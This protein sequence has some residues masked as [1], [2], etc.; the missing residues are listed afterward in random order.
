MLALP[1]TPITVSLPRNAASEAT[2]FELCYT[3]ESMLPIPLVIWLS[4]ATALPEQSPSERGVAKLCSSEWDRPQSN[5]KANRRKQT[6]KTTPKTA[7]ACVEIDLSP[8]EIQEY[9]QSFVRKQQWKVIEEHV[10]ED[11]WSFSRRLSREELLNAA[12]T[13]KVGDKFEW[14]EG[15]AVVH[16][17]SMQIAGGLTRTIVRA[18]FRGYGQSDD[19]FAMQ[20]AY[21]DL[22]S[23]NSLEGNLVSVLINHFTA[24]R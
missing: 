22:E 7:A 14:T 8:L 17:S 9:L 2:S 24:A 19:Q 6:A 3:F 18:D 23:N 16:V 5:Q 11:S 20:R 12:K 15:I 10:S 13:N 4:V 21:W 1:A